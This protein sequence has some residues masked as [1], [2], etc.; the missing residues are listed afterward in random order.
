MSATP[1]ADAPNAVRGIPVGSRTPAGSLASHQPE[2]P[3]IE[4]K[5]PPLETVEGRGAASIGRPGAAMAIL[6]FGPARMTFMTQAGW[7]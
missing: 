1:L 4:D 5:S 3:A 7:R 6:L 2:R